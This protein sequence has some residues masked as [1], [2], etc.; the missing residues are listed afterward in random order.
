MPSIAG[1]FAGDPW[2]LTI[3]VLEADELEEH[4]QEAAELGQ[5]HREAAVRH[6][7]SMLDL[8]AAIGLRLLP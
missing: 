8:N 3:A 4:F 1:I 5:S 7:R 6:R 2:P